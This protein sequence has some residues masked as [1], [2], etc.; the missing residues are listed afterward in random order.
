MSRTRRTAIALTAA[1]A[2]LLAASPAAHADE[3]GTSGGITV[4]ASGSGGH[5][6]N[7]TA[8]VSTLSTYLSFYGYFRVFGPD[9][10][11]VSPTQKW[12][13][14]LIYITPV[15]RDYADGRQH[16]SE[17]WSLQDDGT[18]KLLGR[19]CVAHPL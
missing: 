3:G 14:G 19:P 1:A 18:F 16:C 9:Y 2:A 5:V 17:G 4:V 6:R 8:G 12:G 10:S 13:V 11:D 15:N 7:V